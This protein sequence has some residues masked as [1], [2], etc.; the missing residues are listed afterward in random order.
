MQ[1]IPLFA[2]GS[3]EKALRQQLFLEQNLPRGTISFPGVIFSV[4][5]HKPVSGNTAGQQSFLSRSPVRHLRL[6]CE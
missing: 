5:R 1:A 4:I 6:R 2:P 3:E